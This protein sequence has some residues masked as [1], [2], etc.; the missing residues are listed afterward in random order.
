MRP[1][2]QP[3]WS[4]SAIFQ[5]TI[6]IVSLITHLNAADGAQVRRL[7]TLNELLAVLTRAKAPEDVYQAAVNILPAVTAADRAALLTFDQDGI[8]RFQAWRDLSP[9]FR[10]ALTGHAPWTPGTQNAQP[11]TVP[12]VLLEESLAPYRDSFARERIRAL[13]FIPLVLDGAAPGTFMLCYAEPDEVAEDDL[14]IAQV[15]ASH[16]ALVLECERANVALAAD[17][18]ERK[19]LQLSGER[20]AR[21]TAELLNRIGPMLAAQLDVE[22]LAQSVTDLATEL[23]GAEFGSFFHNA[24]NERGES[25]VLYTLSGAPREAFAGFSMPQGHLPVRSYLAAPVLSR[26]GEILGGLFFGH[27]APGKFTDRHEAILTGVAAQAAIAMDNARLF[28]QAQWTQ[29][30]LKRS[31]EELRRANQDLETFAYSASHDLQ[32]PLRSIAIPAQLLERR[33]GQL[34]Q[35][36]ARQFLTTIVEGAQRMECLIRDVLAYATATKYAEEPLASVDSEKVLAAV[37]ANLN[38]HIEQDGATITSGPLPVISVHE[39]R[40]VQLFQ[41]LIGNA[42]KYRTKEAP[43]IHISAVERDGWSVF[44]VD[45]NG[46]GVDRKFAHQIFELFKRLHSRQEY[47]GSGMGLAICQRIVEQYGGRIWLENS[48]LGGGSTFCFA[49]PSRKR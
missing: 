1:G 4:E 6:P 39:S 47:P 16:A 38:G 2:Y 24:V 15:I 19:R 35:G 45:D 9:E 17:A 28:E 3:R 33:Y 48:A 37:L 23:V 34:L 20:E 25:Y 46:I 7:R 49:I 13:A 22:K 43:R 14:A 32:E 18:T 40:L 10:Q 29:D 44:S 5:G 8:L 12:D 36:D 41:N 26:S 11:L 30:E 21:K 27:S 42:L 31:N